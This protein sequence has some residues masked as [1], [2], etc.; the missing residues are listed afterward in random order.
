MKKLAILSLTLFTILS[1][2]KDDGYSGSQED[3]TGEWILQQQ[4]ADGKELPL[5]TCEKKE[6]IQ[7]DEQGNAKWKKPTYASPP[8][9]LS[10]KDFLIFKANNVHFNIA[11]NY[12]F[13]KYYGEF[14]NENNIKIGIH[15]TLDNVVY[16]ASYKFKR[17]E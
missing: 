1:C 6:V 16:T 14:L 13:R 8:C 5:S 2:S 3:L 10:T 7:V 17:V 11:T 12:D 9:Y 4:F 15:H